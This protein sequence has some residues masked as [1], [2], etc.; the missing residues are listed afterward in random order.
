MRILKGTDIGTV[1]LQYPQG[2]GQ[3]V[4]GAI[5]LHT[6]EMIGATVDDKLFTN[7]V[8]RVGGQ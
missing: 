7:G 6:A 1:G 3:A 4:R 8:T 2:L 5:N